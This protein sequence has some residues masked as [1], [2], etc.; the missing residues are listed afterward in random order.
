M[1]ND[2]ELTT[3]CLLNSHPYPYPHPRLTPTLTPT[4]TLTLTL[5]VT[6]ILVLA[7]C[8]EIVSFCGINAMTFI[9]KHS[10]RKVDF[11]IY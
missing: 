7:W 5:C 2:R 3:I 6:L 11:E 9:D 4:L 8:F 10:L 1:L